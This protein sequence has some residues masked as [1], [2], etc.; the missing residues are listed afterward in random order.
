MKVILSIDM[1]SCIEK[2]DLVEEC[3]KLTWPLPPCTDEEAHQC[4]ICFDRRIDVV[5]IPWYVRVLS[6]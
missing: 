3:R 4:R 2:S 1:A 5:L 6:E